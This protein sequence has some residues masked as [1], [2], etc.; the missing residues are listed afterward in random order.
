MNNGTRQQKII[1][2]VDGSDASVEAVLGAQRLAAA[3]GADLEAWACWDVP[4]DYEGYYQRVGTDALVR[5]TERILAEAM[6]KAFG[7]ELP[8]NVTPRLVRGNPRIALIEGSKDAS[9]LVVGRRGRG[10]LA[11]LLLG[12]VSSACVTHAHCPVLVFHTPAA[13]EKAA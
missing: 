8:Q 1:V 2:G 11:G 9:M 12:S 13:T 4:E 6:T 3:L 10:R 7:A 5:E